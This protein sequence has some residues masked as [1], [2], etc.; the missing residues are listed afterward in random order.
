MYNNILV[1]VAYDET[2]DRAA[3]FDVARTLADEGAVIT[4]LHVLED[5]PV[6]VAH[7]IPVE[8]AEAGRA[9]ALARLKADLGGVTDVRPVVV[10]GNPGARIVEYAAQHEIDCI[11]IAS[12][13]PGLA[14][15][16]LGSTASRVVRH[17][18]CSVHVLR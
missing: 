12:H 9:E 1:A 17:A 14:D 4:A 3:A 6:H 10:Q 8:Q 11:I 18:K 15:Y 13:R 16:V 2:R 5:I 7:Y